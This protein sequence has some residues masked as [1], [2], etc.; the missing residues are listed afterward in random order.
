MMVEKILVDKPDKPPI[1]PRGIPPNCRTKVA[2][3]FKLLSAMKA[4]VSVH[5]F[6]QRYGCFQK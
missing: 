5:T 6:F 2:P 3:P 1:A 4:L